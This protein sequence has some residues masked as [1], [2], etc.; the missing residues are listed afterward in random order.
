MAR[1]TLYLL[2]ACIFSSSI[3]AANINKWVDEFGNTH[4]GTAP[5]ES[6]TA[7]PVNTKL[8]VADAFNTADP[9]ILYSTESCKYCK[10]ARAFM[11]R[12][13]IAFR[14]YDI[15]RDARAKLEHKRLGGRGVPLLT[16]GKQTLQG[17]SSERYKRFFEI[18]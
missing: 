7:N 12:H 14:E 8:N 10:K 18:K 5:P 17:F 6:A 4:Y 13:K 2:L 9:I 11:T 16:K 3:H 1:C 15:N